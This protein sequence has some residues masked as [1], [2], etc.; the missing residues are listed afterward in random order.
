MRHKVFAT[1]EVEFEVEDPGY[2]LT[3]GELKRRVDGAVRAGLHGV[4][5]ANTPATAAAVNHVAVTNWNP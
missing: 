1:I 4:M 2:D 3:S 5:S